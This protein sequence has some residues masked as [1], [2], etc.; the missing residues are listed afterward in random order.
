MI[1]IAF[2][3]GMGALAHWL[4]IGSHVD[5]DNIFTWVCF[6]LG[7]VMVMAWLFVK[8]LW[9]FVVLLL[10]AGA[11]GLFWYV[12]DEVKRRKRR[13]DIIKNRGTFR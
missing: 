10:L 3:F 7:P 4:W 1:R 8:M 9:L 6:L 13:S 12:Y 11:I 2:Y 5:P